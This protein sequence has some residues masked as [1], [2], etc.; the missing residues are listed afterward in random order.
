MSERELSPESR[1]FRETHPGMS[2]ASFARLQA[3]REANKSLPPLR[4]GV[5]YARSGGDVPLWPSGENVAPVILP[6]NPVAD[7]IWTEFGI[8]V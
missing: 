6:G 8:Q 3:L 7:Y 4:I 1:V 5:P 2:D